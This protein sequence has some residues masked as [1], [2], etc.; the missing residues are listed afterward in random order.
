M[1]NVCLVAAPT[2]IDTQS[3]LPTRPVD[4]LSC[5]FPHV[6]SPL[7]LLDTYGPLFEPIFFIF[8]FHTVGGLSQAAFP[9]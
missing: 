3:H 4:Q 8:H 9:L 1:I 7:V 2:A 5:V 6:C